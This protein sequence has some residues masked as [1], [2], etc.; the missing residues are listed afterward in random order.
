MPSSHSCDIIP[1]QAHLLYLLI[2][3]KLVRLQDIIFASIKEVSM[4][5]RNGAKIIFPHLI[6]DLY[7]KPRVKA[8]KQD[9]VFQACEFMNIDRLEFVEPVPA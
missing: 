1:S 5:E 8:K 2:Q 3:K 7:K 4:H 6:S 9:P